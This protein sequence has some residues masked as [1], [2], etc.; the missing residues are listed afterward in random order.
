MQLNATRRKIP[1]MLFLLALC[2]L[3]I[4][5]T[6]PEKKPAADEQPLS[7]LSG[8][9]HLHGKWIEP[10]YLVLDGSNEKC[11]VRIKAPTPKDYAAI[12]AMAGKRVYVKG[13]LKSYLFD[14]TRDYKVPGS[15]APPP[16]RKGWIVRM[17]V[18]EIKV[19]SQPFGEE[20]EG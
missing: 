16:F 7:E 19:I 4:A 9:L 14:D 15:P 2:T 18:K 8:V 3:F 17:D 5:G 6:I 13:I 11:H 10:Y 20:E 12:R 1:Q